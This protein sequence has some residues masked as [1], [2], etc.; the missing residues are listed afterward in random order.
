MRIY[1]KTLPEIFGEMPWAYKI[2]VVAGAA[3]LVFT[4]CYFAFLSLRT[5]SKDQSGTP[6]H[7]S[8]GMPPDL[9]DPALALETGGQR[10]YLAF[11][12][13]DGRPQGGGI[14][15]HLALAQLPCNTWQLLGKV[16][17]GRK[18]DLLAPDGTTPLASG[19]WRY[20]TPSIVHDPEDAGR[21]WKIYAYKY[22]WANNVDLAKRYGVIVYKY[23]SQPV[24]GKWSP[25]EW[26]FSAAPDFPP[27][28]YQAIVGTHLNTL[29][30]ALASYTS[31][32]RPSVIS[33]GG[34]LLMTLSAFQD[35]ETPEAI[36]LLGS[37][38]HGKTWVYMGKPLTEADAPKVG[39]YTRLSGASLLLSGGR[40]YLAA[41]L[42]DDKT[43]NLGTF[44]FDFSDVSAGALARD[45][46]GAPRLLRHIPLQSVSPSPTGGGFSA[47]VDG[48][49]HGIL[50]SEMSG[51][52]NRFQIFKTF[53]KFE[54][55]K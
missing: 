42:G 35:A 11:T 26:L 12:G 33:A 13:I 37:A 48:C 31:Y 53:R 25:E 39:P 52:L 14:G 22:F 10:A 41:V 9:L 24:S 18:E 17:E 5:V 4:V 36:I 34:Y 3:F 38:D 16:F 45:E 21:E 30:S 44:I 43:D 2:V 49:E 28:P 32:S 29:S 23:G 6:L 8:G 27:P 54:A 7:M 19:V 50:T 55:E 20:E 47:Y 15:V 1:G 51:L 40:I 46:K